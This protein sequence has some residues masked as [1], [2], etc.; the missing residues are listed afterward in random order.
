MEHAL[1][2]IINDFWHKRK[3]ENFDPYNV[4][5]AIVTNIPVRLMTYTHRFV[6]G[7]TLVNADGEELQL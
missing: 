3:V 2:L 4:L 6:D 5:L 7:H 1:Y